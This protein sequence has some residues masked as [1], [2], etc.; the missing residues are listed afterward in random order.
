MF[1]TEESVRYLL[2]PRVREILTLAVFSPGP[3]QHPSR[4][5]SIEKAPCE[6]TSRDALGTSWGSLVNELEFAPTAVLETGDIVVDVSRIA[7]RMAAQGQRP[8]APA[9]C[10]P[11]LHLLMQACLLHSSS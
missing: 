8:R 10:P 5:A 1:A 11:V 3:W 7:E 2:E 6:S 4:R 9:N